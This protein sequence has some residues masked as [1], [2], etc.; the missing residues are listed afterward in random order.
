MKRAG[1][2]LTVLLLLLAAGVISAQET[3]TDNGELLNVV[4]TTTQ[5]ADAVR[6]V[7]GD[8]VN[9]TQLMGAGVDPHLY[10][11]TESD[12]AAMNNADLVVYSGLNL[13]GQF[14]NVLDSLGQ[15]TVRVFSLG[16][17]V[18]EMGFTIGGFD[19]S[20]EFQDVDDPHF[21]FDPRNW[22][23]SIRELAVVLGE[24]N[25]AEAATYE[26]NA[27]AYN[28]QLDLLYEWGVEALEQIPEEQRVLVTSHDAFQY[29]GDAFGFEVEGIQ[30]LSTADEAG[31]GDIQN[32]VNFIVDNEIPVIFVES[33]VSPNTVESV[34]E[35]VESQGGTIQQGVRELYSDAMGAEGTFAETYIGMLAENIVTILQSYDVEVPPLPDEMTV[36]LPDAL[37]NPDAEAT[38][39]ATEAADS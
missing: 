9:L 20:D 22:Q 1:Q 17:P 25:P 5:A 8:T 31:V 32:T 23:I 6:V 4:A 30:G 26:A 34:I 13:E 18:Q 29:F 24:M 28:E 2:I 36:T 39:E 11:P 15:T 19:L 7:A 12:I 3:D 27:E 35:A 16:E 38:P 14:E 37:L 21:W 10:Q 33:S